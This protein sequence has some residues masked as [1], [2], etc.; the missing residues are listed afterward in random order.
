MA[1]SGIRIVTGNCDGSDARACD[2]KD[3]GNAAVAQLQAPLPSPD[4]NR[5]P[6][7]EV[8]GT[9]TI[10]NTTWFGNP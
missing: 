2:R 1:T 7:R 10:G 6:D 4:D 5:L 3:V 8:G 9:L